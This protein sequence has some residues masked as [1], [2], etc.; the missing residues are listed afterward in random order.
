MD[1][2]KEKKFCNCGT[3]A[4]PRLVI[5]GE[6]AS[7]W[8]CVSCSTEWEEANT[9]PLPMVTQARYQGTLF[10]TQGHPS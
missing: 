10:S 7:L 9:K 8:R 1:G 6:L 2:M 5:H 3:S 4:C